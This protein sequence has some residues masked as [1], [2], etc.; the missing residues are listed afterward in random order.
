VELVAKGKFI[1]YAA[2]DAHLAVFLVCLAFIWC[3]VG[4]DK[5]NQS[6]LHRYVKQ[7]NAIVASPW[8]ISPLIL[9][10]LIL[11]YV[12]LLR[13]NYV[14]GHDEAFILGLSWMVYDGAPIYHAVGAAERWAP[15]YGPDGF[16]LTGLLMRLA[17]HA[18]IAVDIVWF[19][20]SAALLGVLWFAVSRQRLIFGWILTFIF[21]F[22][23]LQ[24]YIGLEI[25]IY[26]TVAAMAAVLCE[27]DRLPGGMVALCVGVLLGVLANLKIH[28]ILY[29]MP[30]LAAG[31]PRHLLRLRPITLFLC[32]AL[33]TAV[34]PFMLPQVSLA[35]YLTW[36]A[37]DGRHGLDPTMVVFNV[38]F[39]GLIL[40]ATYLASFDSTGRNILGSRIRVFLPVMAVCLMAVAVIGGKPGAGMHHLFPYFVTVAFVAAL[41]RCRLFREIEPLAAVPVIPMGFLGI[42]ITAL[43]IDAQPLTV[44]VRNSI[45]F[46]RPAHKEHTAEI[47]RFLDGVGSIPVLVA[48]GSA[49][50]EFSWDTTLPAYRGNRLL[51]IDFVLED[52]QKAGLSLPDATVAALAQCR[53]PYVLSPR[54]QKPFGLRSAYEG[55]IPLYDERFIETFHRVYHLRE[56]LRYHDVWVCDPNWWARSRA[57]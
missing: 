25:F 7:V 52:M 53:Y 2:A 12:L 9:I 24:Q 29:A 18:A 27:Q 39:A 45:Y 44:M 33:L 4:S 35:N 1:Y 14:P 20:L 40:C 30:L 36:L 41:P 19:L 55:E 57:H 37:I 10:G 34:F 48:P 13:M 22:G 16:L 46:G 51:T 49:S 5:Q 6:I 43:F 28:A 23:I 31:V 47:E 54:G 3:L 26:L 32:G 15:I 38:N 42:L 11:P 17:G 21:L 56:T 50:D 8:Y